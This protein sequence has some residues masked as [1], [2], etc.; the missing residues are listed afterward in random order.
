MDETAN[1]QA[2]SDDKKRWIAERDEVARID[3]LQ[4]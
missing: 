3:D 2:K 4:Y 1:V